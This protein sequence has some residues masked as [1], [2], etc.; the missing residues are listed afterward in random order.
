MLIRISQNQKENLQI[1]LSNQKSL[2]VYRHKWQSDKKIAN[3]HIKAG[4][5]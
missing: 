4:T 1:L 3:L 2:F 5:S